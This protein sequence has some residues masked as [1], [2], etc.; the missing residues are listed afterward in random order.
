MFVH[1]IRKSRGEGYEVSGFTIYSTGLAPYTFLTVEFGAY[2]ALFVY[3]D[4]S[5]T[6]SLLCNWTIAFL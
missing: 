3:E 1:H 5:F 6:I 4:H 2:G